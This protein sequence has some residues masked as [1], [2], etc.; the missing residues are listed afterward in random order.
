MLGV[1]TVKGDLSCTFF[2]VLWKRKKK[3]KD[4]AIESETNGLRKS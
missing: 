1:G 2:K 4:L 3:K